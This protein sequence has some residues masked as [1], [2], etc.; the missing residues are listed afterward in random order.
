MAVQAPELRPE[1]AVA[2]LELVGVALEQ[3]PEQAEAG[4]LGAAEQFI[5]KMVKRKLRSA[6]GVW[7]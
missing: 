5:A 6:P 4:A 7:F 3:R 2:E 1:R